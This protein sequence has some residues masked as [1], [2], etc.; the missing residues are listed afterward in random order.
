MAGGGIWLAALGGSWYYA[1]AGIVMML[2]GVLLVARH[3]VGAWLYWL[4]LAGT[5][6]WTAWE[7]G[8]D[9]WRWVPRLGLILALGILVALVAPRRSEEHTSELQSLMRIS[10]AV[11]CLK[12]KNK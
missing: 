12:T 7:S 4:V 10:Y 9:Y 2:S 11:F 6:A 1:I 5:A 8:F 3:R